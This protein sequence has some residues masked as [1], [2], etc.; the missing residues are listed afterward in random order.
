MLLW[1]Q[2]STWS[3]DSQ[4]AP[5]FHLALVKTGIPVSQPHNEQLLGCFRE[6]EYTASVASELGVQDSLHG[7]GHDPSFLLHR[8]V[9]M[10]GVGLHDGLAAGPESISKSNGPFA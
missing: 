8:L 1:C 5:D 7:A 4:S 2:C 3:N 9:Y 10:M 6:G